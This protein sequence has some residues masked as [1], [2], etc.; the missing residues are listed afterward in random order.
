MRTLSC[1][2]LLAIASE[3]IACN[4]TANGLSADCIQ[5]V[6]PEVAQPTRVPVQYQDATVYQQPRQPV[7]MYYYAAPTYYQ[8]PPV[9]Y[10]YSYQ[11]TQAVRGYRGPVRYSGTCTNGSCQ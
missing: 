10:R 6:T 8:S 5:I 1:L 2:A 4:R 3:A 9:T 7:V 11:P